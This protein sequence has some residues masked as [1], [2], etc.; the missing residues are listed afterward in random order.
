MPKRNKITNDI[1][2]ITAKITDEDLKS[3]IKHL[4]KLIDKSDIE[5]L[6]DQARVSIE[7]K[8]GHETTIRLENLLRDRKYIDDKRLKLNQE[9]QAIRNQ[10]YKMRNLIDGGLS[11]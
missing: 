10:K 7:Q 2:A 11:Y 4:R 6:I 3:K 1:K 5:E 8:L 9:L